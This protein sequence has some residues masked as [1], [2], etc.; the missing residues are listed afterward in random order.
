MDRRKVL[1]AIASWRFSPIWPSCLL[2]ARE[3]D[4]PRSRRG[5]FGAAIFAMY[6]VI[7]AHANDHAPPGT[8]IQVSGGLL[9]VY[10]LGSI[11]GPLVAGIVDGGAWSAGSFHHR[12]R[13]CPDDR[14]HD[15]ADLHPR[16]RWPRRTS[17]RS[18]SA[19]GTGRD[20]GDGRAGGGRGR[21]RAA[22]GR[23]RRPG[24]ARRP[25]D[26]SPRGAGIGRDAG[27]RRETRGLDRAPPERV[28]WPPFQITTTSSGGKPL[29]PTE[30]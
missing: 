22:G 11:I 21:G 2:H 10:G 26:T 16:R 4:E 23:R 20:A 28:P 18:R 15:L 17:R 25:S 13:A 8:S 12:R 5:L 24:H 6:P 3:P 19:P 9:M 27:R 1:V 14:L 29:N 30:E 7:V